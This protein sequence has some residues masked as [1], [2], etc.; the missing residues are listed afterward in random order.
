MVVGRESWPP[1]TVPQTEIILSANGVELMRK[2][3]G[4]GDYVIGRDAAAEIFV[5]VEGVSPRHGQLIVNYDEILI[6][7]LGSASGVLVAGRPV[8]GRTRLWPNQKVQLGPVVLETRRIKSLGGGDDTLSPQQDAVRRVLPEEFLRE[9]KYEIGGVIAQGGMGAI[10]DAREATT[11]RTV[12]MKVMLSNLSESDLLRF[13]EEAQVTSQLEHPNIVPIYELSVDENGQVFYTMKFVQGVTLRQVLDSLREGDPAALATYSLAALLTIF[14]KVCDAMAFA[15]SKG[16]IHRDLKPDNVMLGDYGEV[17]VM[18]WGL[19][20]VLGKKSELRDGEKLPREQSPISSARSEEGSSFTMAGSIV[21]TPQYMAP[22][23]ARG[24]VDTLDARADTYALGA[25]LYHLLALRP[26]IAG[27]DVMQMIG[28][29]VRGEIEP[30]TSP[31]S[32]TH[33]IPDSLAAV[34]RKAMALDPVARYQSVPA[35]QTEIAA[36]QNGFATSAEKAGT[37]RQ[38]TLLL[39]RHKAASIGAAAVLLV[40]AIFGTKAIVEGRRA[41]RTLGE[42]RGTAPT[43]E[44]QSHA[45]LSEGKLDDAL[46]KI[47][48]A[49][50]L[51]P[52]HADYHLTRANLFQSAQKLSAAADEYR[53]VLALRPGD[54]AAKVNL[55]LCDKLLAENGGAAELPLLLQNKLL[56]ALVAQHRDLEAAPLARLLNRDTQTAEATIRARLASYTAQKGWREIN[57]HR[58]GKGFSVDLGA[59]Q[60]GDLHALRGLP[61]V[62]LSLNQTSVTDL[63]PLAGLPLEKLVLNNSRVSDLSP[64]RGMKLRKLEIWGTDVSDLSPLAAMPLKELNIGYNRNLHDLKPLAGIPLESLNAGLLPIMD[65]SPLRGLPLRELLFHHD[66]IEMPDFSPLAHSATLEKISLPSNIRDIAFLA[67]LPKLQQVEFHHGQVSEIWIPAREFLA[68]YGPDVPEIKAARAA[69]AAAGLKD[70]AISRVAVDPD[71]RLRLDLH[72]TPLADL[73]PFRGL[74]IKKLDLVRTGVRDLE[75][76]RGMPIN[77]LSLTDTKV[78]DLDPLGDMPIK[79]LILAG[80]GV[81]NLEPLRGMPLVSLHLGG[82]SVR[83]V[84]ILAEFQD[85][86]DIVLPDNA[87]NVERLRTLPKLRYLSTRWNRTTDHPAQT[88]EEFWKEFDAKKK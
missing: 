60:L 40:G 28:K 80:V 9:K 4:P 82:S 55:D 17:L 42:L 46:A 64:L 3:V 86:E 79:S 27:D 63:R 34:C 85:L 72:E 24:D 56:D 21:G 5:D 57:I 16:V 71:H 33:P 39:K 37:W 53:R 67:T 75:P 59:L 49:V 68:M 18:D 43:F 6:A 38:F 51:A 65:I 88:A 8:S 15:H 31:S 30:L 58:E 74:P 61:I 66:N 26:P 32:K 14:Q 35:L 23:Q 36:F 77:D 70:L 87:T 83:D 12:A 48:Y 20:K 25:I 81:G 69:L 22:E 10:L 29:V 45:L 76:L 73:A 7:D 78:R 2:T 84:G 50:S 41:E 62:E 11:H 54:A 44:A 19:A 1:M 13:I 52:D 47:G